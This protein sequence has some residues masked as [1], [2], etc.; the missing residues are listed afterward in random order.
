MGQECI[1]DEVPDEEE[2]PAK[3]SKDKKAN[4]PDAGKGPGL[5]FKIT[6]RVQYKTVLKGKLFI[7]RLRYCG[8]CEIHFLLIKLLST[9]LNSFCSS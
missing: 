8:F 3:S 6:S 5:V 2:T 7:S 9:M 1:V 4:G